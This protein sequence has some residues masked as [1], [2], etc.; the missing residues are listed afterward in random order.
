LIS[1]LGHLGLRDEAQAPL[2]RWI[3]IAP[4]QSAM[5]AEIGLPF[6]HPQDMDRIREGLRAAGWNG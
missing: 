3:A 5:F 6:I 1:S 4:Q 2:T